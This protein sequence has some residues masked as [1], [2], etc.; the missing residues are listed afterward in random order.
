[1]S[2]TLKTNL[3]DVSTEFC[4]NLTAHGVQ[5][6]SVKGK[7]LP[8]MFFW[9]MVFVLTIAGSCTHLYFLVYSYLQ[10]NFYET[11]TNDNEQTPLF[12]HVTICDPYAVSVLSLNQHLHENMQAIYKMALTSYLA[13]EYASENNL[14]DT[15]TDIYMHNLLTSPSIYANLP[16]GKRNITSISIQEMLVWCSFGDQS[17]GYDNFTL[18]MHPNYLNCYTFKPF[19]TSLPGEISVGPEYG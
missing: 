8:K 7:S 6:L 1:M 9:S 2:S 17:C 15:S 19:N 16:P 13:L 18:Y 5:H 10:Y 12:P 11:V 3:Q 4:T 14:T